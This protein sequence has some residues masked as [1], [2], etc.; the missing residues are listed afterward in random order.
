LEKAAPTLAVVGGVT[1]III[2]SKALKNLD[3]TFKPYYD[4]LY[5]CQ[6]A[7]DECK[8]KYMEVNGSICEMYKFMREDISQKK[9]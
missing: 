7:F 2:D 8:K 4:Y 5:S 3:A 6:S 9:Y 1:S